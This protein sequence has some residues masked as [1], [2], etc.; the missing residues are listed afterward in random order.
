MCA[1]RISAAI[2]GEF[3]RIVR[4]LSLEGAVLVLELNTWKHGSFSEISIHREMP[5]YHTSAKIEYAYDSFRVRG[6][7]QRPNVTNVGAASRRE[8]LPPVY[9]SSYVIQCSWQD[10]VPT[11]LL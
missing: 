9:Q 11:F 1:T 4:E 3:S 10:T 5:S 2:L 8:I 6:N 7:R